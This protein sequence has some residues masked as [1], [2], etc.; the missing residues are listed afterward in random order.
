MLLLGV[1]GYEDVVQ[2]D[3]H[4]FHPSSTSSMKCW[5]D[6]PAFLSPKGILRIL[7]SPKRVMMAT[8][9][10][11][12]SATGDLVAPLSEIQLAEHLFACQPGR[13]VLHVGRQVHIPLSDQVQL[14][15][16]AAWPPAAIR[17]LHHMQQ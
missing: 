9:A 11:S 3:E 6:C 17:L 15:V 16:V 13:Q 4:I 14:P 10:T 7:N 1:P 8:L 2:V 12:C 5:K